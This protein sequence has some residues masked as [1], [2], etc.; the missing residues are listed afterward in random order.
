[1]LLFFFCCFF[2]VLGFGLQPTH[3]CMQKDRKNIGANAEKN[4]GG[5]TE[6]RKQTERKEW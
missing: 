3:N 1:M 4:C 6:G 2:V 5:Q